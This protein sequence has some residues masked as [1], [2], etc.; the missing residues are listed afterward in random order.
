MSGFDG[1]HSPRQTVQGV[2]QLVDRAV[3]VWVEDLSC[4]VHAVVCF[5]LEA[6]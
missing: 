1:G 5:L 4:P 3:P 6:T 2:P